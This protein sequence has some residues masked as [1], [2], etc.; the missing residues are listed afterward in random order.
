MAFCERV[1]GERNCKRRL[2]TEEREEV[3][4]IA[5]VLDLR[6]SDAAQ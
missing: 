1:K 5:S 4:L 2:N 3:R 6:P